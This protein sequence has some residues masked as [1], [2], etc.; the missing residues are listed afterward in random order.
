MFNA[1]DYKS[2]YNRI[3]GPLA[4]DVGIILN[5]GTDFD[6][7]VLVEAHVSNLKESDLVADG[8]VRL[9][10]LRLIIMY[11]DLP[12]GMRPLGKQDRIE[13]EGKSYGV[14]LW[15]TNSRTIAATKI[16]VE[17]TVRG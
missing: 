4:Q 13:I 5:N 2:L 7:P 14:I 3:L 17:A 10:D 1:L 9:G 11:D 6:P 8:P 16:A 12:G 15:D